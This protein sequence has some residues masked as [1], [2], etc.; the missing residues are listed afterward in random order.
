M[1]LRITDTHYNGEDHFFEAY[2]NGKLYA[3]SYCFDDIVE[4]LEDKKKITSKAEAEDAI[5]E[6]D[7]ADDDSAESLSDFDYCPPRYLPLRR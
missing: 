4:Y 3:D 6:I 5:E 7:L 2:V 1:K